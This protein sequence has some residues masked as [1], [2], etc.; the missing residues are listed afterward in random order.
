MLSRWRMQEQHGGAM[1]CPRCSTPFS[2][3]P[4][5]PRAISAET[6]VD[7]WA[8]FFRETKNLHEVPAA[9]AVEPFRGALE[10]ARTTGFSP[11]EWEAYERAKMAEQDARGAL[12]LARQEGRAEGQLQGR[13]EA[14]RNALLRLLARRGIALGEP[15]RARIATCTES[16]TLDRW[17]DQALTANT[18][19]EVL[20]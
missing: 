17:F 8:Y 11:E 13:L 12:S 16:A 20:D 5:T 1:G 9:L 14:Q 4:S 19:A 7:K 3:C 6:L 15:E 18:A 2:S 10:V